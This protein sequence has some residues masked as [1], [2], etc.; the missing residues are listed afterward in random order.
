MACSAR[1]GG[2][3]HIGSVTDSV[4]RDFR[5]P[6]SLRGEFVFVRWCF[7]LFVCLF[8]FVVVVVVVMHTQVKEH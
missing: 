8:V 7:S 6:A 1:K 3:V 2:L 5:R 4:Q